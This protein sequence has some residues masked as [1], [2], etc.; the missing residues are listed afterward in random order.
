MIS[1]DFHI[2]ALLFVDEDEEVSRKL[3]K[4]ASTSQSI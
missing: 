3:P 4:L 1:S 2:K